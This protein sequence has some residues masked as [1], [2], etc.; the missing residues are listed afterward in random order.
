VKKIRPEL[1]SLSTS[2]RLY[3]MP[4]P[5]IGLTGGIATGKST[6]SK[7]LLKQGFA[8]IDADQLVKSI[9]QQIEVIQEIK[10]AHT[11][12]IIDQEI[13][14]KILREAFFNNPELQTKIEGIIYQRM[15]LAFKQAYQRQDS[16]KQNFIIYDVP[17]LFE[18]RLAP[19]VDLKVCVWSSSQQ[20][21]K[22]LMVRDGISEELCLK[23]LTRQWDIN[24]KRDQSDLVI[25]ND[26]SLEQLE[27]NVQSFISDLLL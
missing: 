16:K 19:L 26:S 3:Q 8:I 12:C 13:D 1:I 17:L 4:V 5:V 6:V 23:I 21:I 7:I 15:P 10:A 18:K 11:K 2:T 27:H 14:F 24:K 25:M 9:Y 20:Q 22:R